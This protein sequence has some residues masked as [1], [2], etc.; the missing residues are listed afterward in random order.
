MATF[1]ISVNIDWL[2]EDG[3][4]DQTIKDEVIGSIANKVTENLT[5]SMES[6]VSKRVNNKM[7]E[8]DA[9][10]SGKL[11]SLMEDFFNAP[12]DI[13]DRWGNVTERGVTVTQKLAAACDNFLSRPV[14]KNGNPAGAYNAEF[15]THIDYIVHKS[16]DQNM[17]WAIKKAVKDVTDNLK[18]RISNE[19]TVQMGEKLAGVVGLDKMI[20]G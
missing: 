15:K 12:K 11:N 9:S 10:I 2:E 19:I 3:S 7:D 13:T 4:I 6:E 1:N 16:I 8:L 18:K 14:D 20:S 5:K 17:E